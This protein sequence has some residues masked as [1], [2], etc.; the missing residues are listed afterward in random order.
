[1][2]RGIIGAIIGDV[3]GSRFEWANN[4]S[5]D[6]EFLTDVNK[7]TDD[8]VMTCA[9]ADW[10]VNNDN[11]AEELR[12]WARKYP[13]AGYG[14]KF[15]EWVF[16]KEVLPPYNSFGNGSAMR[17]SPVGFYATTFGEA[18]ELAKQSAE[19]THNH[20]EG[21]KGAQATACAIFLARAGRGKKEIKKE[22]EYWFGYDLDRKID[23][24]RTVYKF[25]ASCQ[26]S[27]PEAIIAFLESEDYESAIRLAVSIGGDSDTIACITGG[28][29][30]AFYGVPDELVEEVWKY[31]KEDVKYSI[32]VFNCICNS[33]VI[34]GDM[35]AFGFE[36]NFDDAYGDDDWFDEDSEMSEEE[37]KDLMD[38][39]E[40]YEENR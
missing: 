21:I 30:A 8:T 27:V 36:P 6:F 37:L 22:I 7:F 20:P 31:L 1:M 23:D 19:V 4:R 24:I 14:G 15:R 2:E 39:I 29:A 25:D 16:D 12:I 18:M 3:V 11:L 28:I 40:E 35:E 38:E 26:G 33:R 10:L 5:T 32:H 17:V 34:S 13:K 9:V